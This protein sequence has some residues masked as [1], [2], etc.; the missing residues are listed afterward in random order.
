MPRAAREEPNMNHSNGRPM[1]GQPKSPA[2]TVK[3][4]D[5]QTD[6]NIFL[7]VPNLIGTLHYLLNEKYVL[8][9]YGLQATPASCSP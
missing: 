2:R 9:P 6:E 1:N 5:D 7:F 8:I 3:E 4:D